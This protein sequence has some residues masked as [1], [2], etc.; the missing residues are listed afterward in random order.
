[1]GFLVKGSEGESLKGANLRFGVPMLYL[2]NYSRMMVAKVGVEPT[3][4]ACVVSE[5]VL[6]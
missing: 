6:P 3:T 1:M 4:G 5:E 2:L